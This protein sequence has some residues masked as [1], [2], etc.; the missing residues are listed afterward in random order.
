MQQFYQWVGNMIIS[1]LRRRLNKLGQKTIT[2]L[3]KDFEKKC[4]EYG[5]KYRYDPK[6]DYSDCVSGSIA[7][8][9]NIETCYGPY[10]KIIINYVISPGL[11][12]RCNI[13]LHG[14]GNYHSYEG[15]PLT[16]D[17]LFTNFKILTKDEMIIKD[18]IE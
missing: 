6:E 10:D 3:A 16:I 9:C 17:G 12:L 15:E 5:L 4:D 18:I 14:F 7:Y 8:F 13:A 11:K 1:S 2:Q